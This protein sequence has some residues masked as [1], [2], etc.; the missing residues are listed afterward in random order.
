MFSPLFRDEGT[1]V[2]NSEFRGSVNTP[3]ALHCSCNEVRDPPFCM[4]RK[5]VSRGRGLGFRVYQC[6]Q[7]PAATLML[8]DSVRPYIGTVK[9]ASAS[10]DISADTWM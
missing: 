4:K 8:R 1:K 6:M 9:S 5:S 7:I 10:S 3:S 2:Q